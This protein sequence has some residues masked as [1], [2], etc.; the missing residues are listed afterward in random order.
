A[1]A[2]YSAIRLMEKEKSDRARMGL[3]REMESR[4]VLQRRADDEQA[5]NKVD[6]SKSTDQVVT[7][8][9]GGWVFWLLAR[10]IGEDAFHSGLAETIRKFP[11]GSED[12]PL[13]EDLLDVLRPHAPDSAAF[14]R[15]A[16]DWI[17]GKVLPNLFLDDVALQPAATDSTG[18]AVAPASGS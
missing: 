12:A 3:M 2:N 10:L 5:M 15:F 11:A 7:Y 18:S 16:D 1:L 4:Y 17:K 13:V 14:D 8:D 6:G 9:R